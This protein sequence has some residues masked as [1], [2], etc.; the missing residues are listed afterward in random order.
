MKILIDNATVELVL[1]ALKKAKRQCQ[2]HNIAPHL[3]YDEA[4]TA[5]KEALAQP[6]QEPVE[7][8]KPGSLP[9]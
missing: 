7:T 2:Y 3:I 5:I 9:S 1:E 4:I 8:I 6:V